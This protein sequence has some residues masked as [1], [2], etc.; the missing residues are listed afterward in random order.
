MPL[1]VSSNGSAILWNTAS[2]S[3]FDNRFPTE[4]R[5]TADASDAI[6]YYFLYGPQIDSLIHQY[7]ELTGTFL[8]L[9][10]QIPAGLNFAISRIPYWTIDIAGYGWPWERDTR[11]PTYQERYARW[12][13]YGVFCPIFRT[14]GH[15]SNDTNGQAALPST[16]LYLFFGLACYE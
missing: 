4:L 1:L 15:R 5:L 7:R 3:W 2:R 9:T 14:H 13:E 16:A 6:D 12:Y 10:R 8:T 11:D